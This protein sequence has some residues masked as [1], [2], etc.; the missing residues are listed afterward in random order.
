MEEIG[1]KAQLSP[2][3]IYLYFKNKGELYASLNLITL[4]YFFNK[5]EKVYKKKELSVDEKLIKFK[6]I[7]Y[8]TYKFDPLIFRNIIHMQVEDSLLAISP[9]LLSKI[10]DIARQIMSMIADTYDEGVR[11]GKFTEGRGMVF[12]DTLWG[13]FNGLV[14]WEESKK[15]FNPKKDFLKSTLDLAINSLFRGIRK[16][17]YDEGNTT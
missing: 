3:T 2:A 12:A 4:E 14:L 8:S 7:M 16:N 11:L 17:N 5:I 1:E 6:N 9:D 10:N 15:K 13:L